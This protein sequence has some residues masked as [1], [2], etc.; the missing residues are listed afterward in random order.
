MPFD[1]AADFFADFWNGDRYNF[2]WAN[3]AE[4]VVAERPQDAKDA[5]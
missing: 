2:S 4:G 1:F 3:R 5:A